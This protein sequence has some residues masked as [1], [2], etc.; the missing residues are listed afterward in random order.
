MRYKEL[1]EYTK[2]A[3]DGHSFDYDDHIPKGRTSILKS[4]PNL[5]LGPHAG[6]ELNMLLARVKP[7][8]LIS[9][10][11]I[12]AYTPYLK[13]G[14]LISR[15]FL[16]RA[17]LKDY[18]VALPGEENRINRIIALLQE[19]MEPGQY[20]D[21]YHARLGRLLGYTKEQIRTFLDTD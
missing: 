9:R 18:I 11:D 16:N 12:D 10:G 17:N 15:E 14:K 4:R 20:H 1:L 5:D 21:L 3:N 6:K 7:A 13:S 8:A 2:F 19:P